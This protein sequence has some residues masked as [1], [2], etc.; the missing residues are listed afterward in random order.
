MCAAINMKVCECNNESVIFSTITFVLTKKANRK[1]ETK[2]VN[3]R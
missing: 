1:V 3:K 2:N